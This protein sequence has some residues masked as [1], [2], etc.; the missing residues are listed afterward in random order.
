MVLTATEA[1]TRE[2]GDV[3]PN[4]VNLAG[5]RPVDIGTHHFQAETTHHLPRTRR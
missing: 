2:I 3:G 1:T 4:Q 5:A